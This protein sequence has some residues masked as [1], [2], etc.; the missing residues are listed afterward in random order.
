MSKFPSLVN[1]YPF[2]FQKVIC[3]QQEEGSAHLP[4]VKRDLAAFWRKSTF[5]EESRPWLSYVRYDIT[6]FIAASINALTKT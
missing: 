1:Q 3:I 4:V 5:L 6:M 2:V